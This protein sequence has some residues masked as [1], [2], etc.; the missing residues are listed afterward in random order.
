M[1]VVI[2][3]AMGG[4]LVVQGRTLRSFSRSS[5]STSC[6]LTRVR[7]RCRR[8]RTGSWKA[9]LFRCSPGGLGDPA[10]QGLELLRA[11]SPSR[12]D[13]VIGEEARRS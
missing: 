1:R 4:K 3:L 10:E 12:D 13:P 2:P 9:S 5:A 7:R 11:A 8:E 6:R